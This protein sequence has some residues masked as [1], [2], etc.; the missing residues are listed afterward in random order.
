MSDNELAAYAL[1]MWANYVE[2]GEVNCSAKDA[3]ERKRPFNALTM[4]QMKGVI[5]LR[6]L[7]ESIRK[8]DV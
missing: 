3:E 8:Q 1:D 4:E 7:A 6:E 5:R 2:T